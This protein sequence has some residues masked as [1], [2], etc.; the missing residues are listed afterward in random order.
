M[1][2]TPAS[3]TAPTPAAPATPAPA[4]APTSPVATGAKPSP[5]TRQAEIQ[6]LMKDSRS[7]Y[8][9]GLRGADGNTALQREYGHLLEQGE[10]V[11]AAAPPAAPNPTR[12]ALNQ[13]IVEI[14]TLM[15]DRHSAYWHGPAAETHQARWRELHR[16]R[17]ALDVKDAAPVPAAPLDPAAR[18]AAE[19]EFLATD[20]GQE[21]AHD[22]EAL[23]GMP[24]ALAQ[25]AAIG[26]TI[27]AALPAEALPGF[28]ERLQG[29]SIPVQTAMRAEVFGLMP[30][31]PPATPDQIT[32]FSQTEEGA[33]LL[34]IWGNDA[35]AK[36][37]NIR[38]R[39]GR[40]H[41]RAGNRAE[42][43]AWGLSMTVAERIALGRA[44]ADLG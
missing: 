29:L 12:V 34:K 1:S 6:N 36:V 30:T 22:A 3:I 17:E 28:N 31:Q 44:M 40:L 24:A 11:A 19:A 16:Q 41:R 15:A 20:A 14:E 27:D 23:G 35:A 13:Q 42:V 21:I 8:W 5:A 32:R 26:A 4:P 43:E 38:F 18:A 10:T 25:G 33:A 2:E 37:A 9:N 7:E 39:V